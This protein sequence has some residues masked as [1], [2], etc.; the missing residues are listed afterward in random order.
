MD[1]REMVGRATIDQNEVAGDYMRLPPSLG[2]H[3]ETWGGSSASDGSG[4]VNEGTS[5]ADQGDMKS[6]AASAGQATLEDPSSMDGYT[7]A[8]PKR[9]WMVAMSW[10]IASAAE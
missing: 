6:L 1:W 3:K 5:A 9:G 2:R 7:A 4:D 8:D 10:V